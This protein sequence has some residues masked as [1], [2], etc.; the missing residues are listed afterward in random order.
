M[1][2]CHSSSRAPGMVCS[3]ACLN[4]R[5]IAGRRLG[6]SPVMIVALD[7]PFAV[8]GRDVGRLPAVTYGL[9]NPARAG[10]ALWTECGWNLVG[11]TADSRVLVGAGA[12]TGMLLNHNSGSVVLRRLLSRSRHA[13]SRTGIGERQGLH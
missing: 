8:A 9:S 5:G 7:V 2:Y 3:V 10:T 11:T 13:Q 6:H 1:Q 4:I 12:K